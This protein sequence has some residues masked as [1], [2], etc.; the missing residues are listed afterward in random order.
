VGQA[1]RIP[2]KL[3]PVVTRPGGVPA[4]IA[5]VRDVS[6]SERIS[7]W[8]EMSAQA[9]LKMTN[10]SIVGDPEM[11]NSEWLVRPAG[12]V[13]MIQVACSNRVIARSSADIAK[14]ASGTVF[15]FEQLGRGGLTF[16]T[17]GG[18]RS[19]DLRQ[20]EALVGDSD[21][22]YVTSTELGFDNR[23][24]VIPRDLIADS[25]AALDVIAGGARLNGDPR[26]KLLMTFL[27]EF[28]RQLDLLPAIAVEGYASNIASLLRIALDPAGD[29]EGKVES[30]AS[31]R[32]ARVHA[33]I[34]RR[35]LD[36][37]LSP[38][39]IAADCGASVRTIH[40]LFAPTGESFSDYV[41]GR[42]LELAH[43]MLT[44]PDSAFQSVAD[45]AYETGFNS[46]S[47]FYTRYRERFGHAPGDARGAGTS[48]N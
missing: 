16:E 46:L 14:G 43:N 8:E 23:A 31:A 41:S 34:E 25:P 36:P 44:R 5:T 45:I 40:N 3:A 42:R 13:T 32:L 1:D 29:F 9:G 37:L 24:W 7:A 11:F 2:R 48:G 28:R 22:P 33:A 35:L 18:R 47:T 17:F 39:R 10:K 20:G 27:G 38:A 6:P 21:E 26:A 15:I 19:L 30:I 4:L 12:P